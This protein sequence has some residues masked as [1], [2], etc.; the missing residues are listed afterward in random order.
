M[1]EADW[2]ILIQVNLCFLPAIDVLSEPVWFIQ[3]NTALK[4]QNWEKKSVL[5]NQFFYNQ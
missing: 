1:M 5:F 2:L 3:T 4:E